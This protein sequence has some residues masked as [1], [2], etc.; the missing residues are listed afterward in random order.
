ML[1]CR[2]TE[3]RQLMLSCSIAVSRTVMFQND[4]RTCTDHMATEVKFVTI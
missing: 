4:Q 1:L 3:T 2:F